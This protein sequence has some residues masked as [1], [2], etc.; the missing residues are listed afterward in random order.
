[1]KNKLILLLVLVVVIIPNCYSSRHCDYLLAIGFKNFVCKLNGNV[2]VD[3]EVDIPVV[4]R[5]ALT[6]NGDKTI[7]VHP[8]SSVTSELFLAK[9]NMTISAMWNEAT[10]INHEYDPIYFLKF[11]VQNWKNNPNERFDI[12]T[13]NDVQ[14]ESMMSTQ[15]CSI[16]ATIFGVMVPHFKTAIDLPMYLQGSQISLVLEYNVLMDGDVAS[17]SANLTHME[18]LIFLMGYFDGQLNIHKTTSYFHYDGHTKNILFKRNILGQIS[19]MWSDFG[20][21][22]IDN[23]TEQFVNSVIS[24]H[25]LVWSYRDSLGANET[26]RLLNIMSRNV[27]C[28]KDSDRTYHMACFNESLTIYKKHIISNYNRDDISELIAA[29]SPA[30]SFAFDALS[31]RIDEQDER[32]AEQDEKIADMAA[33]NERNLAEQAAVNERNL[34]EQ[35]EKIADMA[36]D[37]RDLRKLLK[38][39]STSVKSDSEVLEYEYEYEHPKEL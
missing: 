10:M 26:D 30:T 28:I 39:K 5:V 25:N 35:D 2:D 16:P 29:I 4:A 23:T 19:Y 27:D 15:A 6:S 38:P 17:E 18:I 32:I 3:A 21:T 1:M 13:R 34:A 7:S 12:A 31:G 9:L 14:H 22:A 33:V 24:V 8:D 11:I 36:A 37:L 20:I